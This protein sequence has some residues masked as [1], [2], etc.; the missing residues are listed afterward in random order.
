MTHDWAGFNNNNNNNDGTAAMKN[1]HTH[2]QK[3]RQI[4]SYLF[5]YL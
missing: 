2:T 3:H 4:F 5:L 1:I